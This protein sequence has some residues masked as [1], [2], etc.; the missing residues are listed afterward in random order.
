MNYDL[1]GIFA[2]RNQGQL[3]SSDVTQ[4][5]TVRT[6][7]LQPVASSTY[8]GRSPFSGYV[9]DRS[10]RLNGL[11]D[12]ASDQAMM[13]AENAAL[14]AVTAPPAASEKKDNSH[15]YMMLGLGAVAAYFLLRK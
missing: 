3:I 10:Q 4:R 7:G 8:P 5:R 15:M 12:A 11:G 9:S 1:D 14:A 6:P 13:D 2:T